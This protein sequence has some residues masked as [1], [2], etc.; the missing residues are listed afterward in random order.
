MNMYC[1]K[2]DVKKNGGCFGR[3][4]YI[5]ADTA[6]QAKTRFAQITNGNCYY[7]NKCHAFHVSV[8]KANDV[9]ISAQYAVIA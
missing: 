2:Y 4:V 1:V 5:T 6:K 8:T 7:D 3:R 9:I